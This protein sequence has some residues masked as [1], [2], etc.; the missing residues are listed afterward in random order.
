MIL[1][2]LLLTDADKMLVWMKDR[3]VTKYF[4]DNF[5]AKTKQDVESYISKS[6]TETN[7]HFAI[8]IDDGGYLGT[9]SL[10]NIDHLS[11]NAEYAVVLSRESIGHNVAKI[12]TDMILA[13]AF[14]VLKLEK[15]YFN[16]VSDNVRAVKFYHKYG[17][18]Y[19]GKFVRHLLVN[20][21]LRDL[22]WY[23]ILKNDFLTRNPNANELL[24][25]IKY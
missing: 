1:R 2:K 16:V 5:E 15:V 11:K 12:A 25:S 17:F 14:L 13:Y 3:E 20:G 10:K 7:Q 8:A 6:F 9:I 22:E 18:T 23:C 4:R 24:H 21:Q 19:E